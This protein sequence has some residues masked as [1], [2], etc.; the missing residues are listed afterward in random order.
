[1]QLVT[2]DSSMVHALGYDAEAEELEVVFA[3]GK[4]WRY[5]G[6]PR[7]VYDELL[8]AESIGSYMRSFVIDCYP[9]YQ[10]SRGSRQRR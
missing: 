8:A 3:S 4:I 10:V 2:V 9:D 6:V 5:Q 7:K 1:M